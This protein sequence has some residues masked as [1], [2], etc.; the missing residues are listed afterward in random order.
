MS[1][2]RLIVLGIGLF[3]VSAV[4]SFP[5]S[6]S[7]QQQIA[8]HAGQAQQFLKN[9]RP[10]LAAREYAAILALDPN[11]AEAHTN[12]G[13]LH[14]FNADYANAAPQL[15]DALKLRPDL[16]KIQALLG[17]AE[18]RL[19]QTAQARTDLE[20]AFVR[21]DEEKLKVE[22]G[23]QLIEIYYASRDLDRAANIVNVLRQ[24]KPADPDVLYV[25]HKIYSDQA[26]ETMLSLAMAGPESA[27]MHQVMG[28]ELARQGNIEGAIRN[29]RDAL[30]A[31][32]HLPG[33][34]FRLAEMLN[35]S[36]GPTD[37]LAAEKEYIAALADDPLDGKS[38]DRLGEIAFGRSDLKGA[39]AHLSKAVELQPDDAEANLGLAKTL[40]SMQEPQK[41]E[42]YLD[43]AVKLDPYNSAIRFRLASLYRQLGR[44]AEADREIAEF[45]RLRAM[46]DKLTQVYREMRLKPAKDEEVK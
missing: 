26:D 6:T 41:A 9:K 30:K 32:P 25:A 23:M 16:W 20:S 35:S 36:S 10:D 21:V 12:L 19:G 39:F 7:P 24:V 15:R 1:F 37:R 2:T 38:E 11:N 5:Q 45:R 42:K 27:R 14:Y 31:D 18:K 4:D 22:T 43:H 44:S 17:M 34:H 29:Y 3:F 40:M 46:K 33:V 28:D 8:A 13:V